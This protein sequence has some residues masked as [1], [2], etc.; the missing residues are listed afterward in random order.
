LSDLPQ[1][2][3]IFATP[4]GSV[5]RSKTALVV[6]VCLAQ[7]MV[8]LD[9]TVTNVA[10]PTIARDLRFTAGDLQWV[11]T[12]YTLAFGGFLLLGGRSADLFGR[13]RLFTLGAAIFTAASLSNALAQS[14]TALIVSR[15]A[16]GI[17]AA[18]ISPAALSIITTST[19]PGQERRRALG[20]FAA[21]SAGGGGIGLVLGGL[22]VTYLSWRWVFFINLPVGIGAILLARSYVP[23]SHAR[24]RAGSFDLAGAILI[25]ASLALLIYA[26]TEANHYGWLSARTVGFGVASV[27]LIVAFLATEARLDAPL[28]PLSI[29]RIRSLSVAA[30]ATFLIVGGLYATFYLGSLYL[31]GVKGHSPLQA[32]LMFLPQSICVAA[33][34]AVSQRLMKRV[35]PKLLLTV[36]LLLDVA[37][38]AYL[39][40]LRVADSYPQGF[41]PGLVLIA[42]GLGL[43]FVPL[44]MTATSDEEEED[45]GLASGVFNTSQ[46]VGGAFGLAVLAAIA[47]AVTANASTGDRAAALVS[48]YTTAF[49]VAAAIALAA[50]LVV[51]AFLPIRRVSTSRE[52]E[53]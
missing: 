50:V 29:L 9:A 6:T 8:V 15:A 40:Q 20:I 38:L 39:S 12:A 42:V 26:V 47:S 3:Q 48:G 1:T 21:I 23:D 51:V 31:Q 14:P 45:Q 49:A 11:V 22:L 19:A 34:S 52:A 30:V 5:A 46:Q 10:L 37:G 32:G 16:Q 17:G 18:L 43:S 53:T 41:L 25:T 2:G 35:T 27:V 28:V 24:H 7:F 4:D 44:T 36:G 13:R 33:F